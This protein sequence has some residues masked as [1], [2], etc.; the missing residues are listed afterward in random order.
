MKQDC[1]NTIFIQI[2][3]YRDPELL[4]TIEDCLYQAKHPENLRFCIAWQHCLKDKQALKKYKKDSR[5]KILDIPYQQTKGVCWARNQ[6]QQHY[7]NEKYTLQIDS[8]HRFVKNWDEELIEMLE[9]LRSQGYKKPLLTSY[10]P[11]YNP[12]N[13][14]AER[15]GFPWQINFDRF[16]SEGTVFY[17]PA[18]ISDWASLIEPIPARF[19]GAHFCFTDGIFCKEVP[20][21]PNY[22]FHGE[23]ISISVR[24]FT[25]GYDMFHPHKV[26]IWHYYGRKEVDKH[27]TDYKDKAE[28]MSKYTHKRN[29]QLLHLDPRNLDFGIYD[30]GNIRSLEN[31]ENYSQV[32]FKHKT[33]TKEFRPSSQPQSINAKPYNFIVSIN[34]DDFMEN[35]DKDTF[36]AFSFHAVN[37]TELYRKD[38]DAKEIQSTYDEKTN[39][40]AISRNFVSFQE[41]TYCSIW[42]FSEKNK[43]GQRI[44]KGLL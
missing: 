23:E 30:L 7:N 9:K 41:P 20:H 35:P 12:K 43:W 14:P 2:A 29:R 32:Y 33:A 40:Y 15:I 4:A 36:W 44:L 11:S 38:V 25:H 22:Y 3:S 13:D 34:K 18:I 8:H 39:S 19:Y 16:N 28:E 10:L 42:T 21:D 27:W 24:A 26:L 37:G 5:F 6:I 31:Y 17:S 1:E